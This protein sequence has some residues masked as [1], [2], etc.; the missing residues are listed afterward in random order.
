[1]R[2]SQQADLSGQRARQQRKQARQ[3]RRMMGLTG[4][5]A[6]RYVAAAQ[7]VA[8]PM[9]PCSPAEPPRNGRGHIRAAKAHEAISHATDN[10]RW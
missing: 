4:Q 10:Q 5:P 8:M 7:P 3:A 6:M 9:G 2:E 1:M